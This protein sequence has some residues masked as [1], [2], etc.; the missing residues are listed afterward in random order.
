MR[1]IL[2]APHK[3]NGMENGTIDRRSEVRQDEQRTKESP[4]HNKLYSVLNILPM[5]ECSTNGAVI[6]VAS[7]NFVY[8]FLA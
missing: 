2:H 3:L 1:R 8:L 7:Q 6:Y 4:R 5:N